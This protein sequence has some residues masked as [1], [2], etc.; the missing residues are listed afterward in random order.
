MLR[1]ALA[2]DESYEEGAIHEVLLVIDAGKPA[3]EGGGAESAR[4][5]LTRALELS[6]NKKVGPLVSFAENVSV[7]AQ[8][9][10]EFTRLLQEALALDPDSNPDTR[11]VNVLAQSR[12]RWLLSRTSDLFAE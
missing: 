11:L 9:K 1:R 3:S 10:A 4:K 5:H 6:R 12:A 8:N 2:L 7:A